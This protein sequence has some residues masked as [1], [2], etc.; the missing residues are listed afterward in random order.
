MATDAYLHPA[1][2]HGTITNLYAAGAVLGGYNPLQEGCGAGVSLVTAMYAA[3][4]ILAQ[5]GVVVTEAQV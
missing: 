5:I 1:D 3:E 2:A 4:Q